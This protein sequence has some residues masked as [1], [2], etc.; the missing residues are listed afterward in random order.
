VREKE[1]GGIRKMEEEKEGKREGKG[2][3]EG[4]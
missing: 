2:R 4:R 1:E 3:G